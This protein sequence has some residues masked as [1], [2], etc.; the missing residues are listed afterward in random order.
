MWQSSFSFAAEAYLRFG[1]GFNPQAN[2]DYGDCLAYA[3][4]ALAGDKLLF[5]GEDFQQTD[6]PAA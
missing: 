6:I 5:T 3:V 4:A 1:R 2:L